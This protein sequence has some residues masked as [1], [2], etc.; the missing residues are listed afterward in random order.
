MPGMA[1]SSDIFKRINLPEDEIESY[2]MHWVK[3]KKQEELDDYC[4]RI[5][6][7]IKHD[8]MVLVGVSFGGIIVQ[9]LATFL[10]VKKVIIISSVKSAKEFP[11]RMKFSRFTNLHKCLPT[12]TLKHMDLLLK[13]SYGV[14]PARLHLYKKYLSMNSKNYLDWALHRLIHWDSPV[15][16][17]PLIHIHGSDDKVFPIKYISDCITVPNA[18]HVMILNRYKWFNE[19]LPGLI[20]E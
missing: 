6:S 5:S 2:F 4:R 10:N 9:H 14:A 1:A 20:L 11:R 8:Q 13:Y 16:P 18:T 7:Q 15:L 3:P 17:V 19:Q 12:G